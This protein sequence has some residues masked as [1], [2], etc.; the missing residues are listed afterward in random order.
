MNRSCEGGAQ[1]S[2]A[3]YCAQILF[4]FS[5]HKIYAP[6]HPAEPPPRPVCTHSPL[7]EGCPYPANGFLCW[8]KDGTCLRSELRRFKAPN[9]RAEQEGEE[10]I[11]TDGSM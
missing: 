5:A 11:H 4:H 6:E 10:E 3:L 7:C 2:D 1:K 9:R 8:G